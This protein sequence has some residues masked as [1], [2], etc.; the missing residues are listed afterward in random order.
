[1]YCSRKVLNIVLLCILCF[2]SACSMNSRFLSGK[3][4]D[5]VKLSEYRIADPKLQTKKLAISRARFRQSLAKPN[6][7]GRLRMVKVFKRAS[8]QSLPYPIYRLFGISKG[9]P[10]FLLGLRSGDI[11]VA[12]NDWVI[13]D[14]ARFTQY[15][16]LLQG[17]KTAQ[18]EI[19]RMGQSML[20]EYHFVD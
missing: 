6:A 1:M 19:E 10:Y 16:Y 18:I 2:F 7:L 5:G 14:P 17:E 3:G 12:A 13:F 9:D 20:F 8:E 4:G 15:V 11:L